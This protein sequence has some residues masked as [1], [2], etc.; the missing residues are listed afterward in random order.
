MRPFAA[1]AMAVVGFSVA[2]CGADKDAKT[3]SDGKIQLA[4][5]ATSPGAGDDSAFQTDLL[6][7]GVTFEEYEKAMFAFVECAADAGWVLV[8]PPR[9]TTRKNYDFQFTRQPTGGPS[10]QAAEAERLR[11]A[12]IYFDDVQRVWALSTVMP[13][14]ERQE[15]RDFL[16]ACMRAE[17]IEVPEHPTSEDWIQYIRVI[18]GT[19]HVPRRTFIACQKATA[20]KFGLLPG[21]VP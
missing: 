10:D 2:A 3:S 18:P 8:G 1:F 4:G 7:D 5:P 15:A 21:E 6:K 14:K 19:D 11:C 17:G 13:E 16:G 12:E 9:L 20:E